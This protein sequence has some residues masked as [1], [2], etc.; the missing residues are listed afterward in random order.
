[1]AQ[2][3]LDELFRIRGLVFILSFC[4]YHCLVEEK[5]SA[6]PV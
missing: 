2:F 5:G 3:T 4:F 1:M 6:E